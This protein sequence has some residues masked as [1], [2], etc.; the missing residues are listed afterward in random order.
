M[1]ET[2]RY[3]A[4]CRVTLGTL[5]TEVRLRVTRI[6]GIVEVRLMACFT[7]GRRSGKTV[8]MTLHTIN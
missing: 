1:I 6:C 2:T 4:I 5:G 7:S 3:P 8:R